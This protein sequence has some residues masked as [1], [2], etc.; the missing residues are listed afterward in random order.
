[1][2]DEELIE[3]IR[4]HTVLYDLSHGKYMD[5]D[6]KNNIWKEIGQ[7]INTTESIFG[8]FLHLFPFL[9]PNI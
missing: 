1:M 8:F 3:C 6:F 5:T 7:E 9:H 4:K 2:K